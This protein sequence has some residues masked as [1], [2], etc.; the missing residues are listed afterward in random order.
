MRNR[1]EALW[2]LSE[3]TLLES[4]D[5]LVLLEGGIAALTADAHEEF[6]GIVWVQ[7]DMDEMRPAVQE[8]MLQI[9]QVLNPE[10]ALKRIS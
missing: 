2:L 8:M 5:S 1:L 9:S 6:A 10:K 4:M 3:R 7:E